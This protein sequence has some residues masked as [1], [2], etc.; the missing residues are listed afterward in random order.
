MPKVEEL[1]DVWMDQRVLD[2][3]IE[4]FCAPLRRTGCLLGA[5]QFDR[6]G[7]SLSKAVEDHTDTGYLYQYPV[8]AWI[9]D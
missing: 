8:Q 9:V 6:A 1:L 2:F 5:F 3:F 4:L 7:R